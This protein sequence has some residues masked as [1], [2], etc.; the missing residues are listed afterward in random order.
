[1]WRAF[2]HAGLDFRNVK[3]AKTIWSG[4]AAVQITDSVKLIGNGMLVGKSLHDEQ[5]WIAQTPQ[6]MPAPRFKSL[7]GLSKK[8]TPVEDDSVAVAGVKQAIHLVPAKK[9]NIKIRT[10]ED[11]TMAIALAKL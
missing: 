2:Y 8:K 6:R 11:L 7:R 4:V 10:R 3:A 1:M 9:N 5:L